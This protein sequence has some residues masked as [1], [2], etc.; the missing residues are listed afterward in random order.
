LSSEK[1]SMTP[2][3]LFERAWA[4]PMRTLAKEF[5]ISD[6]G[7][8][9]LC[10]R[11]QIPLP[12][13]GYW[14]RLQFGQKP[15]RT[16]LPETTEPR[17]ESVT[18]VPSGPKQRVTLTPEQKEQIPTIDVA[19]DGLINHVFARRIERNITKAIFDE[20]GM[21]LARSG[22]IV[23]IKASPTGLP[24][25]L[26]ILDALFPATEQ[27]GY[28]LDWP[29]PYNTGMKMI[30]LG[31]KLSF[32]IS[33]AT[34]RTAHQATSEERARQKKDTWWRPPQWDITP[35]GRLRLSL[36]SCE[37]PNISQSWSDGKRRKL[38][39]CVGE[40]FHA[41]QITANAV[42]Q[43]RVD[44]AEAERRRMEERKREAEAAARKAEYDRK[45]EALKRLAHAWKES[46][47]VKGFALALQGTVAGAEV[48]TELKEELEKMVEWGLRHAN[49]LDPLTDLKWV[50]QQFKNPPWLFGY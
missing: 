27:A 9:K 48:P 46:K 40:I 33:E 7:L 14:A 45:A 8:A 22:A 34:N 26:R 50:A 29:A 17:L 13:R 39:S 24:R 44:R 31:E 42:K 36:S 21:L 10:R 11:H 4:T 41:C 35:S 43:E 12:G 19:V 15:E 47:L 18:I 23:P 16:S 32:F 30:V 49:H 1:L 20:R 5:G 6:V 38:E 25:A 2:T 3:E 37:Y 28:K